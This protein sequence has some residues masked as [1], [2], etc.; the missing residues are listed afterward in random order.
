M[1]NKL[2]HLWLVGNKLLTI[3]LSVVSI[4]GI[5]YSVWWNTL[6]LFR[7]E[8]CLYLRD[9]GLSTLQKLFAFRV[10]II[11]GVLRPCFIFSTTAVKRKSRKLALSDDE[12]E[13]SSD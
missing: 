11:G 2:S 5:Y 9:F 1:G 7:V 8:R 13:G 12:D 10:S 6:S 3:I 4:S